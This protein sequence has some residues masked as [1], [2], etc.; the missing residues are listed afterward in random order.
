MVVDL[1]AFDANAADLAR[2]AGGTP[3]RV[4]T[5]SLRVPALVVPG[6]RGRRAS[7]ARWATPCARRC[8]C[9]SRASATTSCWATRPSTGPRSSGWSPRRR[10]PAAVTLMVDGVEHLDVVDSVRSSKAVAGPGRD[11][12]RRRPADGRPA[13]RPE[14]VAAARRTRHP[15]A[16]PHG[17]RP[18]RLRPGRRDDLRGPGRR[19]PR[20]R[21]HPE[22]EV[23]GRTAAQ[24]RLGR[25]AEGA[26]P[27]DRRRP[28]RGRRAGVLERRRLRLAWRPRPPTRWSPRSPPAPG[29]WCPGCSTTTRRSRPVRPPTSGSRSCA[30][31][32]RAWSP[33]PA[34]AWSPPARR[35]RPAAAAR[36][37]R[38]ALHLTG[39]EGAGEVQTPLTGPAAAALRVGDTGVVP[40]RQVRRAGRARPRT[41]TCW[42]GTRSSRPC[43]PTAAPG[44]PGERGHRDATVAAVL[45]H[46]AAQPP[47]LG[48]GRLVCVDGPAGSG[49]TTLAA[50]VAEATGARRAAHGRPLRGLAG[51]RRRPGADPRRDPRAAGRRAARV[52]PALRLAPAASSPSCTPSSRPTCWSSRASAPARASSRRTAPPWSGSTADATCGSS[53]G[54]PATAR[55]P[56]TTGCGGWTTSRRTSRRTARGSAPTSSSRPAEPGPGRWSRE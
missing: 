45:A 41:C 30:G 49:K 26:P 17:R 29:C 11:R 20:R 7:P 21:A 18:A 33:S 4:A 51:A 48:E 34:A 16:G 5:K 53:A 54:W 27:R 25:A 43:R 52:L 2:R 28:A 12:R 39:L 19:R 15:A 47:L 44:T 3:I 40:A 35:R 50:A 46:A 1:D 10:R 38:P 24:V 9:T 22:G 56:A 31:P 13:R 6:A 55:P 32:P 23:A 14:A 42:P 8:G 37:R 36:G